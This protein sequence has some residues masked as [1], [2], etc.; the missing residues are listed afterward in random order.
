MAIYYFNKGLELCELKEDLGIIMLGQ[1]VITRMEI[2]NMFEKFV[3]LWFIV[4]EVPI[5]KCPKQYS[6]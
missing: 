5:K 4:N 2:Y 6:L 1:L 3:Q